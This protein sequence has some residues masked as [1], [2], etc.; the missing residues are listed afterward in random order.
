MNSFISRWATALGV[1][2]AATIVLTAGAVN[3][4]NQ[5]SS[6][7]DPSAPL[8]TAVDLAQNQL[9]GDQ[10]DDAGAIQL[11]ECPLGQILP[12]V[13]IDISSSRP[14]DIGVTPTTDGDTPDGNTTDDGIIPDVGVDMGT[15]PDDVIVGS[16]GNASDGGT[17]TGITV[18]VDS[19]DDDGNGVTGNGDSGA[20]DGDTGDGTDDGVGTAPPAVPPSGDGAT[21]TGDSGR[22][23]LVDLDALLG[24]SGLSLDVPSSDGSLADLGVGQ[25]TPDDPSTVSLI[26][27]TTDAN[28]LDA[29]D[30]DVNGLD[31]N[32]GLVDGLDTG[33]VDTGIADGL[34]D[35]SLIDLGIVD[36]SPAATPAVGVIAL[37]AIDAVNGND[38]GNGTNA[39]GLI[40]DVVVNGNN[41]AAGHGDIGTVDTGTIQSGGPLVNVVA[42]VTADAGSLG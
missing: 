38:A 20:V 41:A 32:G 33:L 42:P 14:G 18:G 23:Q 31:A 2:A 24:A 12:G 25:P 22:F 26:D 7:I 16:N 39:S 3:A 19:G 6:R 34:T 1:T 9:D 5:P 21:G 27:V 4:S 8:V 17:D 13:D 37:P 40:G 30:V 35:G 15:S 36:Q 28:H 29:T 10:L 11:G